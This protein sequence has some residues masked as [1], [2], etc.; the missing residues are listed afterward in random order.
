[1]QDGVFWDCGHQCRVL[2]QTPAP[3]ALSVRRPE[4][5]TSP[6]PSSPCIPSAFF[7]F[8]LSCQQDHNRGALLPAP[9]WKMPCVAWEPGGRWEQPLGACAGPP[10]SQR[11]PITIGRMQLGRVCFC[12]CRALK[13]HLQPPGAPGWKVGVGVR[14]S[15][16]QEAGLQER[17][18]LGRGQNWVP[19]PLPAFLG[20]P[21]P[22]SDLETRGGEGRP[23]LQCQGLARE[24][25]HPDWWP[26]S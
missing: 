14:Q 9:F 6:K 24:C 7:L 23:A 20:T 8:F 16:P 11:T 4:E 19:S 12:L 22:G 3:Q 17:W 2:S 25:A 1:M 13:A 18:G 21:P 10:G 5:Q 15:K 26:R